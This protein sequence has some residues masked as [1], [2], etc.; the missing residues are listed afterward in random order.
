MIQALKKAEK[1]REHLSAILSGTYTDINL[2]HIVGLCHAFAVA[3][4]NS[5]I[6]GGTLRREFIG[7]NSRDIAFDCIADLFQRG[8][9]STM[10]QLQTH[11]KRINFDTASNQELLTHFRRL[12][13]SKV[14]NGLFRIYN[15][16]DPSLGKI[17]RNIKLVVGAL[18]NFEEVERLGESCVCP[19]LVSKLAER[20]QMDLEILEKGLRRYADGTEHILD[21]MAKLSLYF[22]EQD[23][24]VHVL[25]SQ[26][27]RVLS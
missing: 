24:S 19:S 27:A 3:S 7:M 4:I 25:Y 5:K 11:F 20:P 10:V 2:K 12:V 8:E 6:A 18:R 16:V 13:F 22:S 9:N 23:G 14:N 17:I 26:K 15:E 21:L 1:T